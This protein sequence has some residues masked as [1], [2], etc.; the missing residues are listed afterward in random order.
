MFFTVILCGVVYFGKYIFEK[1]G[2]LK[3]SQTVLIEEG[4][5][6]A[7]I[8]NKLQAN[9]IIGDEVGIGINDLIFQI[10]C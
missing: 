6:V 1:E 3:T 4:S 2:P 8:S 5:S 9:G 7:Q 10:G